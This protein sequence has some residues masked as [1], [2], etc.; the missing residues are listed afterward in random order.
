MRI[1]ALD[2]GERRIGV[3]VS[4]PTQTLARSLLVLDRRRV[5]SV[6]ERVG[7]LVQEQGVQRVVVGYPLSLGGGVSAQTER[8]RLFAEALA[9]ALDV[10]VELW[11]ERYSTVEAE[12]ILRGRGLRS[13]K[14]RRWVDA[15]A[16]AVI[17]Q[18]YLDA[19]ARQRERDMSTDRTGHGDGE[20]P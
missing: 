20:A 17:L 7:T 16:A 11:D 1:L 12:S 6:M 2:V 9:Q 13:L 4:D 5:G 18:D 14:R 10:P 3:A 8:V 15:T 19:L